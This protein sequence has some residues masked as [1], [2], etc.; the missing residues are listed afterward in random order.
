LVPEELFSPAQFTSWVSE[1]LFARLSGHIKV[2]MSSGT[3]SQ[4]GDLLAAWEHPNTLIRRFEFLNQLTVQ[5]GP[6]A[7][8]DVSQEDFALIHKCMGSGLAYCKILKSDPK[9]LPNLRVV[10][11]KIRA[12]LDEISTEESLN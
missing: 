12:A 6:F 2:L 1:K 8:K 5:D 11:R 4:N 10:R 3:V 9:N 7:Q